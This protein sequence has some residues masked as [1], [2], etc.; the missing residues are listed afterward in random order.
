MNTRWYNLKVEVE[1][2]RNDFVQSF[3]EQN[4][5]DVDRILYVVFEQFEILLIIKKITIILVFGN[6][7]VGVGGRLRK[8]STNGFMQETI[9]RDFKVNTIPIVKVSISYKRNSQKIRKKIYCITEMK[10]YRIEQKCLFYMNDY[11]KSFVLF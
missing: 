7:G 3:H 1:R 10:T 5:N 11:L 2:Y 4:I 6:V 9:L 8:S